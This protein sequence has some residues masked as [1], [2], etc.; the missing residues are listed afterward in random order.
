MR[1][2]PLHRW[3]T[4]PRPAIALQE[5]LAPQV[6]LTPA[7]SDARLFGGADVAFSS[8]GSHVIAGVIVWSRETNAIV[9]QHVARV[10]CRIPY[11]PGLL[12]FR[13]LP[14]ILAALRKLQTPP[15]VMLC[16]AQGL[17][18]PR[19]LG[20]ASHLG[21]WLQLPTVGCAKS[22]LCG[23]HKAPATA[24]GCQAALWHN[25][26]RVGTVLRTRDGVKP[27]FVSP[28]HLCDHDSAVRLTLAATTRYRLPEP[29]RLAHQ[30]VTRVRS[31]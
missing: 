1:I 6:R 30:L 20:L 16:D 2:A 26:E 27:L 9:E 25:G 17:A 3:P 28:G 5:R 4:M 23:E 10:P 8:D 11:I 12:S 14:G 22:R 31:V 21:L 7:P 29:T 15:Q 24:K 18:H 13:E 19:R